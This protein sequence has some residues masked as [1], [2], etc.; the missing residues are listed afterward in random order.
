MYIAKLKKKEKDLRIL[1]ALNYAMKRVYNLNF[2][3]K[4]ATMSIW[5]KSLS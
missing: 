4:R 3:K 2:M 1:D 5:I